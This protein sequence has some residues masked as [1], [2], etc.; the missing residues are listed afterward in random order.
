M[1]NYTELRFRAQLERCI[2]ERCGMNAENDARRR[3]NEAPAYDEGAFQ[4]LCNE[5]AG[6]E[7]QIRNYG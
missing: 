4:N 6:I 5:F 2:T 7:E 1:D 3:M